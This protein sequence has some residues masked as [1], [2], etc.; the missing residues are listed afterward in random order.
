MDVTG[1]TPGFAQISQYGRWQFH[2]SKIHFIF[3]NKLQQ[4]CEVLKIYEAILSTAL[5]I[6][7]SMG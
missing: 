2:Q 1:I 6:G 3:L 7:I 5:K 4:I